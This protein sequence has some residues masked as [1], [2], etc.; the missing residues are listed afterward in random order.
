MSRPTRTVDGTKLSYSFKVVGQ[1]PFELRD[2]YHLLLRVPL[3]AALGVVVVGYLALNLVFAILYLDL[4]GIANA[5][6]GSFADAFFFSVQ[7]MGTIGYGAMYPSTPVSNALVVCESVVGL[8]VTA[9]ATGLVFVRVSRVRGRVVFSDRV[10]IGPIDGVP[11]LMIR[12]GNARSN[13]IYDADM[14]LTLI[15][16][17]RSKEGT[18]IYRNEELVLIRSR[19]TTLMQSFM[20][21][22][23][24]DAKSPLHGESPESLKARDAELSMALTGTDDTS[25]Q[26]IHARY[27]WESDQL[28]FGAR[29]A[30]VLSETPDGNL[31]LDLGGFHT[32][33]PTEPTP[34]FPYPR[35]AA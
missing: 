12:V 2:L 27:T 17:T 16:T 21:L 22:H 28:V 34:D 5:R 31:L 10:A 8:L 32:L 11:T 30:D 26:P 35:P 29:L 6:P 9:L 4:G 24:I 14:R 33:A 19:A 25:L 3:W 18:L 1:P 7:T 15:R 23:P 20:L 13:R